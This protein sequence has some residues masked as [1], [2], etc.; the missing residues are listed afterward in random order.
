[1]PCRLVKHFYQ[2]ELCCGQGNPAAALI[3]LLSLIVRKKEALEA[4][5]SRSQI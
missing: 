1:M 5:Q 4:Q 2:S 3:D